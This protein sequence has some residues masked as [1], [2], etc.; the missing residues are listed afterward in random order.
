MALKILIAD[1][2]P[3]I[4]EFMQKAIAREGYTVV[5]AC[6]GEDA[7]AKVASENP[8]IIL[9]DLTMP[10]KN[11]F[12]VL[13]EVREKFRDKW[14][15]VIIISA[16]MELDAV[17]KSYN[18]EADHYLTKPCAMENLLKGIRIMESLIPLRQQI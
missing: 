6:D 5:S 17:K 13:K 16:N 1:D 2:D 11:G 7:L 12:D 8:D 9:L 10:K 15:P 3:D 14:R 18:L 4:V